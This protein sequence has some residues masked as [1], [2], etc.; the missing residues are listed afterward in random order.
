MMD[1]REYVGEKYHFRRSLIMKIAAVTCA[2]G[3]G[4][5][6]RVVG[7]S[8]FMFKNGFSG[9]L[10]AFLP[11]EHLD[12]F[13]DWSECQ[14]FRNHP[15]IEVIDFHYPESGEKKSDSL[16]DKKWFNISLPALDDFDIVW[17]D[18]VTQV[19]ASRPDSILT[20]SFFWYDIFAKHEKSDL[21]KDFIQ[22]QR[23]LT[24]SVKPVMIGP[25]YFATP[26][27]R[28]Y[29]KLEP[30]GLYQYEISVR[31]KKEKDILLSCGLGGEEENQ[32]EQSI[33]H[34][35]RE[36]IMP[37]ENLWI[38][39]RF[40][41]SNG[42]KWIKKAD[43]SQEMFAKCVAVC[44]RPGIGTLSDALCNRARIFTFHSNSMFEMSYNSDVIEKMGLGEY[45]KSPHDAYLRAI[46]FARN[47]NDIDKQVYLTSHLRMDGIFATAQLIS[48]GMRV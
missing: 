20:G 13:T 25:D 47:G 3:L 30:V 40:F 44:V 5:I 46:D 1:I 16:I 41:P 18:N 12:Y 33:D 2:N 8:S 10:T 38:E 21:L 32:V 27:V 43:F 9:S 17:S 34:I 37:P 22:D 11:I 35:I 26:E 28:N 4:H 23:E 42:P 14:Y 15:N 45:C 19:L 6:R 48:S 39:K 24:R 36:E 31:E 29:T 7:I